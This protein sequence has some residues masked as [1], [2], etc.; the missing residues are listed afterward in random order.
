M[1]VVIAA[2]PMT[3]TVTTTTRA[4]IT[5]SPVSMLTPPSSYHLRFFYQNT[6]FFPHTYHLFVLIS[7]LK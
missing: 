7:S 3:P 2:P 5:F 1:A 4:I 6:I